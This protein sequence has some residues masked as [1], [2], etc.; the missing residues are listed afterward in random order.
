MVLAQLDRK[1]FI[2]TGHYTTV[3]NGSGKVQHGVITF[4]EG[5]FIV[6]TFHSVTSYNK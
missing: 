3:Y 1:K 6:F 5:G 4:N 2:I